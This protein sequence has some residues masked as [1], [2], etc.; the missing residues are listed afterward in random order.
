MTTISHPGM[1][2][3]QFDQGV[4]RA[5]VE[6][7]RVIPSGVAGIVFVTSGTKPGLCYRVTRRS[8]SCAAGSQGRPCKHR[9]LAVFVADCMGGVTRPMPANVIPFPVRT[10][11]QTAA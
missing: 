3:R 7:L 10:E 5:H 11:P 2:A 6:G 1:T 4:H 8:C 9:C